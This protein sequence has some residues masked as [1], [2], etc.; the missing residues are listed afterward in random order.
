MPQHWE[1][2]I[3]TLQQYWD[4]VRRRWKLIVGCFLLGIIIAVGITFLMPRKYTATASG[5][6][7]VPAATEDDTNVS[8]AYN[9]DAFAKS[10]AQSYVK[11]A[12]STD[13]ATEVGKRLG[14]GADADSLLNRIE[15]TAPTNT[16]TLQVTGTDSTP[17]KAARLTNTWISV[18]ASEIHKVETAWKTSNSSK[19][20]P[21]TTLDVYQRATAPEAPSS[22]NLK[23]NLALGALLGLAV[24]FGLAVALTVF[25]RRIHTTAT[26]TDNMSIPVIG[27]LP[28]LR[29]FSTHK[30]RL[31]LTTG[32]TRASH[33]PTA[34]YGEA[35]RSIRTSIQYI[36]VD[37][38]VRVLLVTSAMASEGKSTL[39]ANLATALAAAG[40]NTILVDGDLRK[41]TVAK[42]FGLPAKVGLSDV[43]AGRAELNQVMRRWDQDSHLFL[44]PAGHIPPNPSEML[45]S[46]AMSELLGELKEFA[47]VIVDAPPVLEVS[48]AMVL[49]GHVDGIILV[50]LAGQTTLDQLD[51]ATKRL[52]QVNAN[53]YGVVLNNVPLK[54]LDSYHKYGY[55]YGYGYGARSESEEAPH[56]SR[57]GHQ[58]PAAA[59]A[60]APVSAP[61]HAAVPQTRT[62]TPLLGSVSAQTTRSQRPRTDDPFD[63]IFGSSAG[64]R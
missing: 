5:F 48:D 14:S 31:L 37:H 64:N 41:P 51:E 29:W 42:T 47:T 32:S 46:K 60:L 63:D 43:L 55:G 12:E 39:S 1:G 6:V 8:N 13:I 59:G 57:R 35:L 15:V 50:A 52:A 18:L 27:A 10:R 62:S 61:E 58:K 34:L 21:V 19:T 24:G 4:I 22:P 28:H 7:S 16:V 9:S 30:S 40:T 20:V 23:L 49:S 53:V 2:K 38:P 54:G 3:V 44:L 33:D 45:G 11:L 36:D 56:S 26:I 17:A 25:D